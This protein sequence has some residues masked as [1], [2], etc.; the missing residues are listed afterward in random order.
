[1]TTSSSFMSSF[2][3]RSSTPPAATRLVVSTGGRGTPHR[4]NGV[5]SMLAYRN[6]GD[7]PGQ[8][9]LPP[10]S[11]STAIREATR[12]RVEA[13]SA[14]HPQATCRHGQPPPRHR[15]I[16]R[17]HPRDLSKGITLTPPPSR[18]A[19]T[20]RPRFCPQQVEGNPPR[21]LMATPLEPPPGK[22]RPPNPVSGRSTVRYNGPTVS[23]QK[24]TT[25]STRPHHGWLPKTGAKPRPI[26]KRLRDSIDSEVQT[27]VRPG[28]G[29]NL[30]G[31]CAA[32]WESVL[33][34]S[35]RGA[36]F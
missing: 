19:G 13:P 22:G 8:R 10:L 18:E 1:M 24:G 35:L 23:H 25:P 26:G 28:D 21:H 30:K 34:P 2:S 31:G 5:P 3:R 7:E 29:S 16:H 32:I 9:G 11:R 12:Q 17:H 36:Y 20:S 27:T 15:V 6:T 14:R 4:R 33:R